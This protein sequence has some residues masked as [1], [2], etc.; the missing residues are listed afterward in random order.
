LSD[1]RSPTVGADGRR[2]W[3][4]PQRLPPGAIGRKRKALGVFLMALYLVMP[5]LS[6]Q[7]YPVLRWDLG[8]K[9]IFILTYPFSYHEL[10]YLLPLALT[11]GF[12]VLC[13]TALQGRVWCGSLCPQTVWLDWLIRPIEEF[14]EG[15]SHRRK[16]NDQKPLTLALGLRKAGKHLSFI[17]I[18]SIL[19]HSFLCYFVPPQTLLT[20]LTDSPKIHWVSFLIVTALTGI[21]YFDFAW[22]R[23]QFCIFLCPY[24]RFQSLLLDRDTP[25]VLYDSKRG[26]P[27]GKK[28]SGDCIDCGLCVRVCPTG[29]DIRNGLQMECIQC[30][31]CSDACDSIMEN[32]SRPLG[33]IRKV[34]PNRL[35]GIS[36]KNPLTPKVLFYGG[37]FLLM[38]LLLLGRLYLRPEIEIFYGLSPTPMNLEKP[39]H[40]GVLFQVRATNHTNQIRDIGFSVPGLD[41]ICGGC[42]KPLDPFETRILSLGLIY[43]ESMGGQKITLEEVFSRDQQAVSVLP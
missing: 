20:W 18:A 29:I 10:H 15:E 34:S 43:P 16:L 21:V 31:R 7:G 35:E 12:G 33:L 9:K 37:A 5:F 28:K 14:F 27:R 42:Q 36:K 23:E 13:F 26:D 2:Q 8:I 30:G 4:Y 3:V 32:L 24:A 22:F 11:L 40:K 1:L 17:L 41:T 6:V 19:S 39:N 38:L 25:S